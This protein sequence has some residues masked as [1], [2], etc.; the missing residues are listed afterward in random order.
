M[1]LV[2]TLNLPEVFTG[3]D[4]LVVLAPHPD[5]ESLACGTLLA[6]AFAGVGAHVICLTD[7]SAS[8]PGS[9]QWKPVRL[10]KKRQAE[11]TQAI[12]LLGGSAKDLS[13][14]GMTDATLYQTDPATAAADLVKLIEIIGARNVF[15]PASQDHHADHK[16]AAMIATE[17][18]LLR[19]D[20]SYYSY[21]VWS[22]W[23]DPDFDQT[24]ARHDP[25]FLKAGSRQ[26]QKR[27]A[28]FAHES[29]MGAVVMDDP[30]G[31]VLAPE[32]IE[33]FITEDE[34]YW[35]MA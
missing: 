11:L 25:I 5:D 7:G 34:V 18:R 10:A 2:C 31:F 32:F 12:S 19:P 17:I 29:Q 16:A 13:W 15:A 4:R 28:I 35:R 6:N 14:I 33:K 20:W 3:R 22:R 30:D 21:P 27:A 24:V 9:L 1:S 26:K 8:H 23:G